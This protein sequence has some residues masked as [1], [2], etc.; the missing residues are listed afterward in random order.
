MAFEKDPNEIGAL[1]SKSGAKGEYL[2]GTIDMGDG[3]VKVVCFA[4][5]KSSD[6]SPAWRV[7]KSVP[8]EGAPSFAP[9]QSPNSDDIGF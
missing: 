2:T 4:V 3:P 9:V 1:W 8:R 5:K 6:K 7:L